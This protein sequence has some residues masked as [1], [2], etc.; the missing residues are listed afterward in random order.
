M[1]KRT[2]NH[3]SLN[4]SLLFFAVCLVLSILLFNSS[5]REYF[6]KK[7]SLSF[8][9]L[10]VGYFLALVD[11]GIKMSIDD[12]QNNNQRH[13][14]QSLDN[15]LSELVYICTSTLILCGI[16]YKF[17]HQKN[18]FPDLFLNFKI[19]LHNLNYLLSNKSNLSFV[20]IVV[21]CLFFNFM[22]SWGISHC[23]NNKLEKVEIQEN[24]KQNIKQNLN[25][26]ELTIDISIPPTKKN[27]NI[28]LI[29]QGGHKM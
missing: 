8:P 21:I 4:F 13:T 2:S 24:I 15:Y 28:R 11:A 9:V 16:F 5:I 10:I 23:L 20:Y 1:K 7:S 18:L 22:L 3:K 14:V 27:I 29:V 17:I 12:G 19:I 26:H 25:N 6:I